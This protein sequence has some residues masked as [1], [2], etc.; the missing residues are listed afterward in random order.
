[1]I[2]SQH[3]SLV[4]QGSIGRHGSPE[5]AALWTGLNSAR[6][7]FP[8]AEIVLA[9]WKGSVDEDFPGVVVVECEDPGPIRCA[10]DEIINLNRQLVSSREG[11][12]A[13][14]RPLVVKLRTDMC[15]EHGR[16]FEWFDKIEG[17]GTPVSERRILVLNLTG[18]NPHGPQPYPFNV[19][20]WLYAGSR[21]DLVNLFAV[22][23]YPEEWV[24]WFTPE[25]KPSND[26]YI[27][28]LC[29]YYAET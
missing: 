19:C 1:M 18:R 15:F 23:N 11:V 5:R 16:L 3:I 29:R 21:A 20:D 28:P 24:F 12:A 7:F 10:G 4:F 8:G 27:A 13:S 2:D 6:R 14:T 22:P 17:P 26:P 25:T 9:T